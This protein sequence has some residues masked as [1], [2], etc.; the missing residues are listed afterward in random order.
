MIEENFR[1]SLQISHG[2]MSVFLQRPISTAFI[3]ISA[4][5]IVGQ[6]FFSLRGA[7]RQRQ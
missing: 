4:L 5:L 1:R 6:I 3:A 7:K 2:S